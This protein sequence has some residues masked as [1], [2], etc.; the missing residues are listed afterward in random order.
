MTTG[1]AGLSCTGRLHEVSSVKCFGTL[2]SSL[3]FDVP[4]LASERHELT[5]LITWCEATDKRFPDCRPLGAG[6]YLMVFLHNRH[7]IYTP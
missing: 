4:T 5:T 1:G 6:D 2:D 3:N 7:Y